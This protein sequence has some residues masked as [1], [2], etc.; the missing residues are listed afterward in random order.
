MIR[1]DSRPPVAIKVVCSRPG[2]QKYNVSMF[3]ARWLRLAC[4]NPLVIIWWYWLV[5]IIRYG[6]SAR[7]LKNFSLE[8]PNRLTPIVITRMQSEAG[9]SIINDDIGQIYDS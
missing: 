2:P 9:E 8:K 4:T 3:R 7:K 1:K 5:R 6:S